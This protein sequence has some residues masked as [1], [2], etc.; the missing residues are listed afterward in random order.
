VSFGGSNYHPVVFGRLLLIEIQRC[1]DKQAV[2]EK[3]FSRGEKK[4]KLRGENQNTHILTK[5]RKTILVR[6]LSFKFSEKFAL[7]E[8]YLK[9]R[10]FQCTAEGSAFFSAVVMTTTTCPK[11]YG[12]F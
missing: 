5:L 7:I 12:I 4:L 10:R 3:R 9:E 6:S 11:A 1:Q 8:M 2:K